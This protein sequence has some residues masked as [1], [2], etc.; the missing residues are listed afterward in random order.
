MILMSCIDKGLTGSKLQQA[1]DFVNI[2]L[3]KNTMLGDT[4]AFTPGGVRIGTP[5]V[6]TRGYL[7]K[8]M[9]DVAHFLD[10]VFLESLN[11]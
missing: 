10:Q 1:G 6:T 11:V 2:T 4:S 7:E 3:N 5:A 8:D 9:K